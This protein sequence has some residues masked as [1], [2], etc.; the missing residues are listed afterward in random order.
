[1]DLDEVGGGSE[2]DP[3]LERLGVEVA[4]EERGG[5]AGGAAPRSVE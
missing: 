4:V 3:E 2:I 1:L 5:L